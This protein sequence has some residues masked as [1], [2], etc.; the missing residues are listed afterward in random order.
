MERFKAFRRDT[1]SWFPNAFCKP[2]RGRTTAILAFDVELKKTKLIT[3]APTA[4]VQCTFQPSQHN[5]HGKIQ[6]FCQ[7]R[8]IVSY[9]REHSIVVQ[10]YCPLVRGQL[11]HPAFI[12]LANKVR[13]AWSL[14]SVD[15]VDLINIYLLV[16]AYSITE[17]QLRL[18][19][20]GHF[21]MGACETQR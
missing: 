15:L 17:I 13:V 21:K 2:N 10:A 12:E 4:T 9:C 5:R 19:F 20:A 11:D 7:Q 18:F 1:Q 3:I 14:I 8:A 16:Y 6:P